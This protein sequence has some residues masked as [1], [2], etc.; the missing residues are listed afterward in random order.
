MEGNTDENSLAYLAKQDEQVIIDENT[1]TVTYVGYAEFGVATSAAKWKIVKYTAAS[2]TSPTGV[3]TR[4][5]AG[6]Y[7]SYT[8]IW[9]NRT[10]LSYSS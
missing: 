7:N 4:Q 8:Q 9:D 3:T 2:A 5:F 10:G 6:G 1:T